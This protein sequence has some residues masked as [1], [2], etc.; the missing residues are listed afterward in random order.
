VAAAEEVAKA[1][2]EEARDR[3]GHLSRLREERADYERAVG[4]GEREPD[5]AY[6]D[7]ADAELRASGVE[8][9]RRTPHG[10]APYVDLVDRHAEA[11]LAGAV[12][13][14]EAAKLERAEF[15]TANLV[16]LTV[17]V[18]AGARSDHAAVV[19]ALVA[20]DAALEPV[21]QRDRKLLALHRLA[22]A[23]P[24]D[25]SAFRDLRHAVGDQWSALEGVRKV[26]GFEPVLPESCGCGEPL[27][28]L[29]LVGLG[30][31]PVCAACAAGVEEEPEPTPPEAAGFRQVGQGFTEGNG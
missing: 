14:A 18:A 26:P 15:V 21:R 20:L 22:D 13:V 5:P 25:Y 23:P 3:A 10:A 7:A 19:D 17:E 28:D 30:G 29:H 11:R 1:R 16:A 12:E 8:E 31:E 9:V 2:R 24:P 4:A 6:E 27:D